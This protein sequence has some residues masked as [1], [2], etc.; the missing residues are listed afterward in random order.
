MHD[1]DEV[2]DPPVTLVGFKVQDRLVELVATPSVTDPVKPLSGATVIVEDPA[3]P[4]L[5]VTTVGFAV[6][7]KSWTR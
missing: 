3:A 7:V 5:S 4:T 6:R 2:P 1:K